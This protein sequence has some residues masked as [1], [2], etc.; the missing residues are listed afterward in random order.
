MFHILGFIFFFLLIIIIVGLIILFK[1]VGTVFRFGRR[2]KGT[3]QDSSYRPHP[4]PDET[5]GGSTASPA[6]NRKKVFD[7]DEG[8]YVDYEGIKDK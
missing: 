3:D 6:P 2:M 1:I 7:D 8:E 4:H 5:N